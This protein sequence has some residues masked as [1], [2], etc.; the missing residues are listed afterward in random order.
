MVVWW[1]RCGKRGWRGG[2]VVCGGVV[3]WRRGGVV[4]VSR[5]RGSDWDRLSDM[6]GV[7]V[8]HGWGGGVTWVGWGCHMGGVEVVTKARL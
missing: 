8:S 6:G 5:E 2:R 7:G 1:W 4:V 3:V